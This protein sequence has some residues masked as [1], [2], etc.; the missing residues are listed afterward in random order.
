MTLAQRPRA[1]AAPL[2]RASS[3]TLAVLFMLVAAPAAAV[4]DPVFRDGF[5]PVPTYYVSVANGSDANPGT[6]ALPWKTI[7]KA[8]SAATAVPPGSVIYVKAGTYP[9]QVVVQR[10]DIS[11]VGYRSTPGDQPPILANLAP[12]GP[13]AAVPELPAFDPADMPLLDGGARTREV[14]IDMRGRR[15]ITLRNLN[16]RNYN[17]YGILAG[18]SNALGEYGNNGFIESHLFDNVNLRSIGDPEDDYRGVAIALGMVSTRFSNGDIVRNSLIIDAFAEAL[19]V[20]G[21]DTEVDNVRVYGVSTDYPMGTDYYVFVSGVGNR[22]H[23]SYAW[24][25]PDSYHSGHGFV[26]KDNGDQRVGGP[27]IESTGNVFDHNVVVN[28]NNE[29]Y[30]VRHRGVHHN[31]FIDNVAYGTHDG[32]SECGDGSGITIRDGAHDNAFVNTHIINACWAIK[33]LDTTEDGGSLE[34]PANDNLITGALVE[35]AYIGVSFYWWNAAVPLPLT[36]AGRNTIAD[37][38]FLNTRN[39]FEALRPAAQMHYANTR[40]QGVGDLDLGEF[41]IGVPAYIATITRAQ[42]DDGCTFEDIP[43]LPPGW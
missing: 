14:A 3:A 16:I 33:I 24:R 10:D 29:G 38:S 36:D 23:H 18:M 6:L 19:K 25:H 26:V 35:N 8:V 12:T 22:V 28:M 43:D 7:N 15:R 34:T 21:D 31:L 40:F 13:G 11:L 5:D 1:C 41:R 42:F 17:G 2:V 20:N 27:R 37:S 32:Q 9:E 30:G 4:Y 39:M